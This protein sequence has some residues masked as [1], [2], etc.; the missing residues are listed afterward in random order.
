LAVADMH[1]CTFLHILES[2]RLLVNSL[3]LSLK[4]NW[5]QLQVIFFRGDAVRAGPPR[6]EMYWLAV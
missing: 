3:S 5:L 2:L 1:I 6:S 4:T